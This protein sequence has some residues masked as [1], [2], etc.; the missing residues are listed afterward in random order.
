MGIK[1][2][3][4]SETWKRKVM[5]RRRVRMM[6]RPN[7]NPFTFLNIFRCVSSEWFKFV[8]MRF[9]LSIGYERGGNLAYC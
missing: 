4:F 3:F 7:I 5:V 1:K 2:Y 8:S 9:H 6:I